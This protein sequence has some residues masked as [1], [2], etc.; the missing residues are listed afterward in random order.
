VENGHCLSDLSP[1]LS[2]QQ[3][4]RRW[5]FGGHHP[6]NSLF[7]PARSR[8]DLDL[9]DF[10]VADEGLRLRHLRLYRHRSLFGT[11]AD[12]DA[13]LFAARRNGLKLV[14][15]FVP[16][17]TSDRHPWFVESS[18]A[19]ASP[20]RDWYIW[21]DPAPG[22]SPP[23]TGSPSLVAARG[24]TIRVPVNITITRFYR[25]SPTSTDAIPRSSVRCTTLCAFGCARVSMVSG[26]M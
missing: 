25:T 13:L 12:F 20:R 16:N 14:L 22:G 23:T 26:L 18:V 17:H 11:M 19:R 1:L 4:R 8:C 10:S 15:D 5:R 2:G 9:A 6:S 7:D 3:P 21:R 24:P